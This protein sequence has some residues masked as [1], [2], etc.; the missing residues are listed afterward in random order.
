MNMFCAVPNIS[1]INDPFEVFARLM[2][3]TEQLMLLRANSLP[4][5]S[6]NLLNG[7][8]SGTLA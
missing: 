8:D 1:W 6:P 2:R 7:S 3:F 4:N 5:R